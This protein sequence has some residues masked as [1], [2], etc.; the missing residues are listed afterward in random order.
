MGGQ[1]TCFLNSTSNLSSNGWKLQ[2]GGV[3]ESCMSEQGKG[4]RGLVGRRARWALCVLVAVRTRAGGDPPSTRPRPGGSLSTCLSAR[5]AC[6][7][8]G[9][10][11][12]H[13]SLLISK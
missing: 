8:R 2:A 10:G 9:E 13:C 12:L 4:G 6:G 11:H 7:I 5:W 3:N 1:A